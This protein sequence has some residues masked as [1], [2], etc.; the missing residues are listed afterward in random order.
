MLGVGPGALQSDAHM[1]GIDPMTQRPRMD[2]ALGVILRLL[3]EEEP[4]TYKGD[5]F[6]LRD[7]QLQLRPYQRPTMPVA[8]ASTISPSGMRAAG[9]HGAGVLSVASYTEEGLA[10]M[11]TQWQF[12]EEAA[13]E[14]GRPPPDR[15]DW[16]VVMPIHLADS[17]E[18][19]LR[20]IEEGILRWSRD[21]F[22]YTFGLPI[23]DMIDSG[24]ALAE[25]MDGTGRLLIGT[26]DDAIA[27]IRRLLEMTGGFG[28]VLSL[29]HEWANREKTLY[30]YELLARYVMPVFQDQLT[31]LERSNRWAREHKDELM[32][33]RAQA[34]AKAIEEH[35]A[36]GAG[37]SS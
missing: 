23:S 13:A 26:P 16:R 17:K 15:R 33:G 2:E 19:A 3:T 5:W 22:S 11:T 31:S 35:P 36:P 9:K 1:L 37:T 21:Y 32:G 29:A 24:R 8:V 27:G 6:E 4:I 34:I 28:T 12:C 30:S 14:A 10:A 25:A 7:A 18:E 20:D